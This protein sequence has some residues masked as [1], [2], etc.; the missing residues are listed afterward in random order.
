MSATGVPL[1]VATCSYLPESM[2]SSPIP[3]YYQE[4]KGL[5]ESMF[6]GSE[7]RSSFELP[8]PAYPLDAVPKVDSKKNGPL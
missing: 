4:P 3:A 6:T 7:I 8:P 1:N 5:D 2:P